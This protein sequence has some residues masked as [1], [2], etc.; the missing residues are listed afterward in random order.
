MFSSGAYIIEHP[1]T[2]PDGI[3]AYLAGVEGTLRAYEALLGQNPK[4]RH[5]FLDELLAKKASRALRQYVTDIVPECR[6]SADG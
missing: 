6:T 3:E 5:V 1:G 2:A 4:S